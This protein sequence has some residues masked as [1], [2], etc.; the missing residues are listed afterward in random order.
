M[1]KPFDALPVRC[2][3][4]RPEEKEAWKLCFVPIW[5]VMRQF[6]AYRNDLNRDRGTIKYHGSLV[7]R[8]KYGYGVKFIQLVDLVLFYPV[9]HQPEI[10]F[11]ERI[12]FLLRQ[13]FPDLVLDIMSAVH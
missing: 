10:K 1:Q 9:R 2:P 8:S 3:V 13:A 7:L 5:F 12:A 4:E 11:L 6:Y